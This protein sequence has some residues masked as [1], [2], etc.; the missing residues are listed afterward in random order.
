MIISAIRNPIKKAIGLEVV[1]GNGVQQLTNNDFETGDLSGWTSVISVANSYAIFNGEYNIDAPN[2]GFPASSMP[3][4]PDSSTRFIAMTGTNTT[5]TTKAEIYQDFSCTDG[6][7]WSIG[8]VGG[9][10]SGSSAEYVITEAIFK[11]GVSSDI[12][13][14]FRNTVLVQVSPYQYKTYVR[15]LDD[16]LI[17]SSG[18]WIE[19][20]ISLRYVVYYEA[21]DKTKL[22]ARRQATNE[23]IFI[24]LTGG[25][26]AD[27][28]VYNQPMPAYTVDYVSPAGSDNISSTFYPTH[29]QD[30]SSDFRRYSDNW[31]AGVHFNGLS[32]RTGYEALSTGDDFITPASTASCRVRAFLQSSSQFIDSV[33][34]Y[35]L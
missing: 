31:L 35:L 2:V 1:G 12:V 6:L 20:V 17:G 26:T 24:T 30:T 4:I 3:G 9:N 33:N 15:K 10:V 8:I 28:L 23:W 32:G 13:R 19:R 22:M 16:G 5:E 18:N 21:N 14:I 29:S 34:F 11:D 7:A 25:E 27:D